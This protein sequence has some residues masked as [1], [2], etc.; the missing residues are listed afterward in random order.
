MK[1]DFVKTILCIGIVFFTLLFSSCAESIEN[2][3]PSLAEIESDGMR[4]SLVRTD[5]TKAKVC[6]KKGDEEIDV[7][8]IK[9]INTNEESFFK[10]GTALGKN[11]ILLT[12]YSCPTNYDTYDHEKVFVLFEMTDKELLPI[13]LGKSTF[14]ELDCDNDGVKEV[15]T[16]YSKG[17]SSDVLVYDVKGEKVVC[18]DPAEAIEEIY[19]LHTEGVHLPYAFLKE[20]GS[21][22]LEGEKTGERLTFESNNYI[23]VRVGYQDL[24]FRETN[25]ESIV[26]KVLLSLNKARYIDENVKG[27][28]AIP[29]DASKTIKGAYIMNT[30]VGYN[31]PEGCGSR[32]ALAV[33][34]EINLS[35]DGRIEQVALEK[36]N[37]IW[38][39]L[40]WNL[41]SK[42]KEQPVF[43][44]IS[45]DFAEDW[46][47]TISEDRL[48]ARIKGWY[49]LKTDYYSKK[50]L[51]L[52]EVPL[53]SYQEIELLLP[54]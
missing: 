54:D 4:I 22:D 21:N 28:R 27:T 35:E 17:W 40:C 42:E 3:E 16:N 8:R 53:S 48:S 29:L 41:P 13:A 44:I 26:N 6:L 43:A 18:A 11:T 46:D 49:D 34:Y 14:F 15:I 5:D 25:R 23:G 33:P 30:N 7:Y 38:G 10:K 52:K 47:I 1:T 51:K 2:K 19:G 12:Y 50:G 37:V 36:M 20:A 39:S 32:I 24:S 9:Y 31:L 45:D